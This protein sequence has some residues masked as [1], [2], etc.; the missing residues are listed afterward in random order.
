MILKKCVK[1]NNKFTY[2]RDVRVKRI[3]AEVGVDGVVG[4]DALARSGDSMDQPRR[5]QLHTN[6]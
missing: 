6:Y 2:F 1:L 4:V 5:L 3:S